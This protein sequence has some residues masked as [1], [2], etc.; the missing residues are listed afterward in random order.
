[1]LQHTAALPADG[2][3]V[4][5]TASS[6]APFVD[7]RSTRRD[8]GRGKSTASGYAYP[9]HTCG[10]MCCLVGWPPL[11]RAISLIG[12]TDAQTPTGDPRPRSMNSLFDE[13]LKLDPKDGIRDPI[14]KDR[15]HSTISPERCG[16]SRLRLRSRRLCGND[17][18]S[19]TSHAHTTSRRELSTKHD[20]GKTVC[21]DAGRGQQRAYPFMSSP[22]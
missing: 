20:G 9:G 11:L 16:K 8:C 12:E 13:V 15:S 17:A 1:M 7:L 22:S 6:P 2:C 5:C 18:E 10:P 19:S 14:T 4:R 3:A 21:A